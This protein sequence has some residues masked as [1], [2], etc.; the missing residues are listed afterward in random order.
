MN[1]LIKNTLAFLCV[2]IL[3]VSCLTADELSPEDENNIT[4][5]TYD[6]VI[7]N[8]SNQ[9]SIVLNPNRLKYAH[10]DKIILTAK[11]LDGFEFVKWIGTIQNTNAAFSFNIKSNYK[12]KAIYKPK[13]A[14]PEL[15][16]PYLSMV[17]EY[18]ESTLEWNFK[19]HLSKNGVSIN[20][21]T[22]Y[23]TIK[24]N[25][26]RYDSFLEEYTGNFP[27]AID[28]SDFKI[29]F[30]HPEIGTVDWTIPVSFFSVMSLNNSLSVDK[31]SIILAWQSISADYYKINRKLTSP[32]S[33]YTE[34]YAPGKMVKN[35]SF[36]AELNSVWLPSV[37]SSVA[38]ND[39][40]L[41]VTPV[42]L[43]KITNDKFDG[44]SLIEIIGKP[45]SKEH[46]AR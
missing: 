34:V 14:N 13:V 19:A 6:L 10:D 40:H 22:I 33:T 18:N 43:L 41:W 25:A 27:R 38:F 36:V 8:N 17:A 15:A 24:E 4:A 39:L 29:S 9:G 45:T 32:T 30:S 11:P 23:V 21:A 37:S 31:K 5:V 42:N 16:K 28:N 20:N 46:L 2:A 1:T 44:N 12:L 35:A 26:L 3:F 7:E